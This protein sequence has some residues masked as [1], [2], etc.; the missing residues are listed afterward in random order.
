MEETLRLREEKIRVERNAVDRDAHPSDIDDF[1]EETIELRERA[2]VPE[3]SKEA[4]VVEE[5]SLDRDVEHHDETIRDT[6]RHTEVDVEDL[7]DNTSRRERD[8]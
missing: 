7:K 3:V 2:E 8:L 6:V 4:R 5:I 1:R